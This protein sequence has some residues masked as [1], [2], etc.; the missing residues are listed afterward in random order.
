MTRAAPPQLEDRETAAA[1]RRVLDQ[2]GYDAVR[3]QERLGTSDRSLA[4]GPDRPVYLRRLGEADPL[5]LL[6]RVF[7]LDTA[8]EPDSAD[9]LLG[10]DARMLLERAGL[11]TL[12]EGRLD[13]TVRVVPHERLLIA[14]DR[15]AE[16]H[17]DHVAAVHGPSATLAHLTVRGPVPRALDVGTGNGVQALLA[18]AHAD[19]VVATDV[20]E[21]ALG[22][23]AFNAALNGVE[24]VELRLGS[25]FEPVAGEQFELVVTNPPY[26]ISP[27]SN[28]LFRDSGLP[29][30]AVS[31]QVVRTL[32]AHLAEGGY[33]S[34]MISWVQQPGETTERPVAWL[35][36]SGCDALIVHTGSDEPLSIAAQWNRDVRSD[37]A[38]YSAAIDRWLDYFAQEGIEQIAFGCAVLRR[39]TPANGRPNWIRATRLPTRRLEPASAQLEVIF[40]AHDFI[41]G[42]ADERQLLDE[43][44]AVAENVAVEQELKLAED[45]WGLRGA[46]IAIRSGMRFSAGLDDVTTALVLG[47]DGTRTVREALPDPSEQHGRDELDEIGINVA[48]QMLE[49]GFLRR[50]ESTPEP[51]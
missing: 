22:F 11:L 45:G 12:D 10:R 14:S 6:L 38:A 30:D 43:R 27:E 25:F 42:L 2:S 46:S 47:L 5:A 19:R 40:A 31:E 49:V 23:A 51:S 39:R 48:R 41:A 7:L 9:R 17:A 16:G 15:F 4:E 18:A 26:V 34:V 33:G 1:V 20:N 28:F 36:G 3:I 32:P 29:K 44:L 50:L 13:G 21:R 35:D 37:A 8:V 24:N